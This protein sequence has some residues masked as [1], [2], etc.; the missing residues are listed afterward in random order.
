[1]MAQA[2]LTLTQIRQGQ[3]EE[4]KLGLMALERAAL[5]EKGLCH[6][7]QKSKYDNR[8]VMATAWTL[9]ALIQGGVENPYLKGALARWLLEQR[10]GG[11]WRHTLETAVAL[12]SLT[13]YALELPGTME[14]VSALLWLN[15]QE[16]EKINV[17]SPHFVR[18][19]QGCTPGQEDCPG[20]KKLP[21]KKG[22][23][24][25]KIVNGLEHKLYYQTEFIAFSTEESISPVSQGISVS[26]EYFLLKDPPK[27]QSPPRDYEAKA[28]P[29]QIKIGETVGV[30]ITIE[31]SEDLNYL[32]I[33]DPLP[34]G[35]EV[36][37]GIK[38]DPKAA[39]TTQMS[40]RDEKVTLFRTR[41][42][43]GRHVF[44][45]GLLPELKGTFYVLPVVA[46]E[47]YRPEM[48]GSGA[49]RIIKVKD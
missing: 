14:G 18:R 49:S 41:L 32:M 21:L 3:W 7:Q 30:R 24:Q 25:L 2:L 5:C 23:N 17:T 45:Y 11:R 1:P 10:R 40:V 28:L 9:Q 42:K 13:E 39:Y 31:S 36:I 19:L 26:K 12:Y 46:E 48:R 6:L 34:S 22:E 16:L 4:A 15:N 27:D 8:S 43:K 33:E 37:Q 47:M 44:N 35:F 38:F 20:K 29:E